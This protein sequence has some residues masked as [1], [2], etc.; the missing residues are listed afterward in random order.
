MGSTLI[1]A[2]SDN[3][4][5]SEIWKSDGTAAG[6]VQIKDIVPGSSGSDPDDLVGLD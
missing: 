5:G 6:T 2:A 4:T 1:F 3:Y